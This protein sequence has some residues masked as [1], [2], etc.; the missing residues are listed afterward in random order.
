M[1]AFTGQPVQEA[2]GG[3]SSRTRCSRRWRLRASRRRRRPA[4]ARA[5]HGAA[6]GY[7]RGLAGVGKGRLKR[8]AAPAQVE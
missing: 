8:L 3:G 4:V 5:G 7:V 6:G 1:A 2:A